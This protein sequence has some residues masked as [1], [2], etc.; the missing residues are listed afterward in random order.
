MKFIV[1]RTSF[2]SKEKP[3]EEAVLNEAGL[4]TVEI[5]TLTQLRKFSKTYG[6]LV[7]DSAKIEIY[8]NY[9]E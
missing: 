8:D 6:E 5:K 2:W 9:R 3:C 4:W 1:T 7:F